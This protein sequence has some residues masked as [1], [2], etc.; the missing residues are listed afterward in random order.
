M[1]LEG[2]VVVTK[3]LTMCFAGLYME[4]L[5]S[6]RSALPLRIWLLGRYIHA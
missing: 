5:T 6:R 3:S 1:W 4:M 2:L